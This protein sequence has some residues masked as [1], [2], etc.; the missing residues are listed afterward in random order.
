MPKEISAFDCS[1]MVAVDS[2]MQIPTLL[3]I[4]LWLL[5]ASLIFAQ[6]RGVIDD[7]DGYVNMRSEKRMDAPVIATVKTREPFSFEC[8]G[9]LPIQR[10]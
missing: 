3:F 1:S 10:A 7:S 6:Q 4:G 2:G 5:L 8:E 9:M